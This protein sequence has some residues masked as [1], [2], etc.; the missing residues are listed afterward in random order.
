MIGR[1]PVETDGRA[2]PTTVAARGVAPPAPL[3]SVRASEERDAF[4]CAPAGSRPRTPVA[5]IAVDGSRSGT[6][7]RGSK[8]RRLGSPLAA[9]PPY[10]A[11]LGSRPTSTTTD[12]SS[13]EPFGAGPRDAVGS[14]PR[15]TLL[16]VGWRVGCTPIRVATPALNPKDLAGGTGGTTRIAPTGIARSARVTAAA[17]ATDAVRPSDS[18]FGLPAGATGTT[19][20][21]S[22]AAST[23]P[24]RKP[25][26]W[27]SGARG[28]HGPPARMS[29]SGSTSSRAPGEL[30]PD[31][32]AG[33]A[34][35]GGTD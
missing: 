13:N 18:W 34:A 28:S 24:G 9:C 7:K 10:S 16:C 32:P 1:T 27:T 21:G 12:R 5:T 3:S 6:L 8:G 23:C 4:T 25:I 30:A 2:A 20:N 31:A 22:P 35:A 17:M 15:A 19:P 29:A 33:S 11:G 26:V 14:S